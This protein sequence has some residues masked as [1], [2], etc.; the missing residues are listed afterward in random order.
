MDTQSKKLFVTYT[1][2]IF[3]QMALFSYL[4]W[5]SITASTNATGVPLGLLGAIIG[6]VALQSGVWLLPMLE[7][8]FYDK[9]TIRTLQTDK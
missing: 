1:L 9:E 6:I 5:E 8:I 2:L 7:K 3:A 4:I